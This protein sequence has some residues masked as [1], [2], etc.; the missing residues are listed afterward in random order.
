MTDVTRRSRSLTL[1]ALM[2]AA[3]G[4]AP[5]SAVAATWTAQSVV[6]PL[7]PVGQLSAVSCPSLR[8]CVAVGNYIRSTAP[9]GAPD[10]TVPLGALW[11][12][13]RWT[14]QAMASPADSEAVSPDGVSC[15]APNACTA[16]GSYWVGARSLPLAERW[17]GSVWTVQQI[18][19]AARGLRRLAGVDCPSQRECFAVSSSAGA[20]G[21]GRPVVARWDGVSWSIAQLAPPARAGS[22]SID[23]VSCSSPRACTAVGSVYRVGAPLAL[24]ERWNGSRW[25]RQPSPRIGGLSAVS[26]PSANWC[27]AAGSGWGSRA[28]RWNGRAWSNLR[29][30]VLVG[31]DVAGLSCASAKACALVGTFSQ[32]HD[33]ASEVAERWNGA[34]W[35]VVPGAGANQ[36]APG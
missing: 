31:A 25:S 12:G 34:R 28:A 24:V 13:G 30:A 33:S 18:P 16:V 11:A 29:R 14:A 22:S 36:A 10:Q 7:A 32:S 9:G 1:L 23:S 5:A 3:L 6:D 35:R 8:V 4:L 19:I 17:N 15:S 27:M 2:V 21:I 26:C 20:A